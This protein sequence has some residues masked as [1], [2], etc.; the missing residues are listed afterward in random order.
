MTT[1]SK[2]TIENE[3]GMS[4]SFWKPITYFYPLL[5]YIIR[6]GS[7]WTISYQVHPS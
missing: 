6:H 3:S 1:T 4:S 5:H 7:I 2:E